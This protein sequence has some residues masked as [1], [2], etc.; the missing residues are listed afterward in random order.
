MSILFSIARCLCMD[1]ED[2]EGTSSGQDT[3]RFMLTEDLPSILQT[4]HSLCFKH[5][6]TKGTEKPTAHYP[7]RPKSQPRIFHAT[8][9]A[10]VALHR[11]QSHPQTQHV[12]LHESFQYSEPCLLECCLPR[13]AVADAVLSK[14]ALETPTA[15]TSQAA[16][17]SASARILVWEC[18]NIGTGRCR[19]A[20]EDRSLQAWFSSFP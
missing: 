5:I 18:M 9:V 20:Y 13:K 7:S 19:L 2:L 11:Y 16:F 4:N 3:W 1:R 10:V 12:F 15:M 14:L 8:D 6:G 17:H